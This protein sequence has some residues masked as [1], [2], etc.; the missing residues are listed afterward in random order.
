VPARV[1]TGFSPGGFSTQHNQWI[2]RDTDAHAW[3]EAWFDRY[4]WVTFDPTPP[5]T[6]ARSQIFAISAPSTRGGTVT[7]R[8]TPGADNGA[9]SRDPEGGTNPDRLRLS[10]QQQTGTGGAGHEVTHLWWLILLVVIVG[11]VVGAW[12]KAVL[13][14]PRGLT[15][16]DR[17]VAE[18]EI[19][20]RIL[21]RPVKTGTTLSQLERRLGSYSPEVRAY[22][23]WLSAGRYGPDAP[24]PARGG[25]RALR[26]ALA[27]GLGPVGRL[28]ALW[29]LPPRISLADRLAVD[30]GAE[31]TLLS[32]RR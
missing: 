8:A 20:L 24:P 25:R 1:A 19:A 14:G 3:V 11:G 2:V 6:P 16:M 13:R 22:F 21:G 17:A 23:Q 30:T 4:G 12:L 27:A 29:A 28:R 18:L 32:V 9:S 10:Q 31:E 26:R 5:G 7:P 15:G